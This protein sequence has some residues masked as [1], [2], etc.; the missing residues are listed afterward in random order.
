MYPIYKYS[1]SGFL[2]SITA[3][4]SGAVVNMSECIG[5]YG[6]WNIRC[7]VLERAD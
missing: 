1:N 7:I 2:D 5:D 4:K 3:L 6:G